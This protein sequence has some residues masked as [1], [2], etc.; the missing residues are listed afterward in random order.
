MA[1]FSVPTHGTICWHELASRDLEAAKAFYKEMFGWELAKSKVSPVAY[2]EIHIGG[3]AVGGMMAIDES[4]GPE[5]PPSNWTAYIAVDNADETA[6]AVKANGGT[7]NH[8]PFDAP[9]VGRIVLCADPCGAHF[10][11]IQFAAA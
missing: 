8:G 4:W 2:D 11:L 1:E 6:E 10:A 3:R 9:G 5:P 7:V